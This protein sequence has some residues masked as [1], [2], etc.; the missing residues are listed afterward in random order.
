MSDIRVYPHF[1]VS[2]E[3][4]RE[5]LSQNSYLDPLR[6]QRILEEL[7]LL[8]KSIS[9]AIKDPKTHDASG[10]KK[11][12]NE[13]YLLLGNIENKQLHADLYSLTNCAIDLW[14]KRPSKEEERATKI[15]E[16]KSRMQYL[17]DNNRFT[18]EDQK[19]VTLFHKCVLEVEKGVKP[20]LEH[21][22]ESI[23]I[24]H[25]PKKGAKTQIISINEIKKKQIEDPMSLAEILYPM[26]EKI[27]R[28]DYNAFFSSY[29]NLTIDIQKHLE[30]HIAI[31]GGNLSKVDRNYD[32]PRDKKNEV[33]VV[34][35]I[36]GYANLI[37][38]NMEEGSLYPSFLAIHQMMLEL[39]EL[40]E[41][42]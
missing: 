14:L 2:V 42:P 7:N 34:Q 5:T 35:G 24:I 19:C 41:D 6:L 40:T 15:K 26:A 17:T 39:G 38:E 30:K 10:L 25:K 37:M 28:G 12:Q 22:S 27:Y 36:L 21:V 31:C 18:K 8:D 3:M 29:D 1:Q 4:I 32:Y 13:V 16:L 11:L 20:S 9:S 33:F 23:P